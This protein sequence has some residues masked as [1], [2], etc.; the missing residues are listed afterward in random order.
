MEGAVSKAG[1]DFNWLAFNEATDALLSAGVT[2]SQVAEALGYGHQTVR[3]MRINV[4]ES[5][6]ART[7]P[8][9]TVWKP[10]FEALV[11]VQMAKLSEA[12]RWIREEEATV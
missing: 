6:S 2:L 7:P 4:T 9:R 1:D 12:I 11:S 3:A 8:P 10:A 5:K